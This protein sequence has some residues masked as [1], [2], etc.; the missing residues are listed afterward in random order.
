MNYNLQQL[1][2]MP[3]RM[4]HHPQGIGINLVLR[5]IDTMSK[6][7]THGELS[8]EYCLIPLSGKKGKGLFAKVSPHRYEYLNQFR[9][10]AIT[11]RCY[12]ARSIVVL[13]E[14]ITF[15]MHRE[16][17]GSPDGLEV[18]HE[19]GDSLNNTDSNL[20]M[21]T[22][23]QNNR[24]RHKKT[25]ADSGRFI[26]VT[27][28]KR[29]RKWQPRIYIDGNLIL[30]GNYESEE[31]AARVRDG[32]VI[33]IGDEFIPRCAPNLEPIPYVPIKKVKKTSRYMGVSWQPKK[34]KWAAFYNSPEDK[35]VWIGAF[36]SEEEAARHRDSQVIALGLTGKKLNFPELELA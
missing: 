10:R 6:I 25:G 8:Q 23:S 3:L 15:L 20:R 27:Y 13:G 2:N 32:A 34:R 9:W 17:M 7:T 36:D 4:C 11:E 29:N 30:L 22:R 31:M 35:L 21:A 18:D 19:D 33:A 28:N 1:K 16:I 14:T 26:G 12:A 5:R 24:N